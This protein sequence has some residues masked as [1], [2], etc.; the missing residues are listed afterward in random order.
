MNRRETKITC[1]LHSLP[2]AARTISAAH[3]AVRR[4]EL[5]GRSYKNA[6]TIRTHALAQIA[7]GL[8][9]IQDAEQRLRSLLDG[10]AEFQACLK[11]LSRAGSLA[12]SALQVLEQ[13]IR[14]DARQVR[15]PSRDYLF[16][17]QWDLRLPYRQWH[18]VLV[19]YWGRAC[20]YCGA[21]EVN[22]HIDHIIP[23]AKGGSDSFSNLTLACRSCNSKKGRM[24]AREFGF[25][26]VHSRAAAYAIHQRG[27]QMP[28]QDHNPMDEIAAEQLAKAKSEPV[29]EQ[30]E[31]P[32]TQEIPRETLQ[33]A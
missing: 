6:D 8:R 23:R 31:D 24:T 1:V 25:P 30:P 16:T 14:P 7:L 9:L 26:E 2:V 15:Q 27:G 20:V 13:C 5:S 19:K 18:P 29:A 10:S 17:S 28:E 12:E 21:S 4:I 11:M 22:L 33:D 32:P 3:I